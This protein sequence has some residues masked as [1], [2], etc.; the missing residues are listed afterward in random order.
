MVR[1]PVVVYLDESCLVNDR[2]R[3][4]P[5]GAG[6]LIETRSHGVVERREFFLS[7]PNTT[8]NRMAL[9][10]AITALRLLEAVSSRSQFLLVSDSEYLVRGIREWVPNW[11]V[12]GWR[13][14]SGAIENVEL[15]KTFASTS[16]RFDVQ[17]TWV[18]GH[19]GHPKN[20]YAD[21]LAVGAA[22]A[23]GNSDGI[24]ASRFLEW[25]EGC[26]AAGRY[27]DYD[28][29]AAF[30]ALERRLVAGEKFRLDAGA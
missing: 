1:R 18:R 21:A 24:R 20:E 27:L 19:A 22:K 2:S 14:R 28:A 4:S 11:I 12:R 30:G 25:L 7:E 9:T 29:D 13:R 3:I 15:W 16:M 17:F 6:G 5:G 8:N 10:G 26:R 23:Q